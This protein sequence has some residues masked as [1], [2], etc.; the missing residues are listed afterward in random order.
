MKAFIGSVMTKRAAAGEHAPLREPVHLALSYDEE[1][2]CVGAVSLVDEIVGAG[3]APVPASWAS[4]RACASSAGT[5][6]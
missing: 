2:G 1:V 3:C 4:R 6:R 5:S